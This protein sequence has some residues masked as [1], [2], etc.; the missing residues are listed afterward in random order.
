VGRIVTARYFTARHYQAIEEQTADPKIQNIQNKLKAL[1]LKEAQGLITPAKK[2]VAYNKLLVQ[3]TR[4]YKLPSNIHEIM[5]EMKQRDGAPEIRFWDYAAITS[6]GN[7]Q[8]LF[9]PYSF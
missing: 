3:Q 8:K 7:S 9:T 2:E 1:T 6:E 4:S 5:N